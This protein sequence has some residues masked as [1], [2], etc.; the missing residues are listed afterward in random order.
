MG[1]MMGADD[2][3][4]PEQIAQQDVAVH[5]PEGG[6]EREEEPEDNSEITKFIQED[7]EQ[8]CYLEHRYGR[9]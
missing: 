8:E 5:E 9:F 3:H 4:G 2:G 6:I 1:E 7:E